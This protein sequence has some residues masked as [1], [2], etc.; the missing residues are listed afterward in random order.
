MLTTFSQ[1]NRLLEFP[2]I[3]S[4]NLIFYRGPSVYGNSGKMHCGNVVNMS[5]TQIILILLGHLPSVVV[6]VVDVVGMV[7]V[8]GRSV[9]SIY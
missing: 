6:V 9:T 7:V 1:C 3:L 4:Q 2:E 8:S 5:I